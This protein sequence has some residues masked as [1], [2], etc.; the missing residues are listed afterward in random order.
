MKRLTA[1]VLLLCS[2]Q[3]CQAQMVVNAYDNDGKLIGQPGLEPNINQLMVIRPDSIA[4]NVDFTNGNVVSNSRD[5]IVFAESDCQGQAYSATNPQPFNW[6]ST[7]A[8][9][10]RPLSNLGTQLSTMRFEEG[11]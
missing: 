7:Y 2:I 10:T 1:F 6:I 5:D 3:F 4:V 9:D 8:S 11:V